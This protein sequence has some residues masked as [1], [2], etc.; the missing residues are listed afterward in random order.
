MSKAAI[1]DPLEEENFIGVRHP[2]GVSI[3]KVKPDWKRTAKETLDIILG[4]C[5]GDK[6]D[7]VF[8]SETY[9]K[10]QGATA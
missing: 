6:L 10:P 4:F 2:L 1:H 8:L 5:Q 9:P 3:Y 7:S